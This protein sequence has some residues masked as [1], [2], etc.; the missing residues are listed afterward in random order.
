M[1]YDKKAIVEDQ[2]R[3]DVGQTIRKGYLESTGAF[4]NLYKKEINLKNEADVNQFIQMLEKSVSINQ[5]R[6]NG[7]ISKDTKLNNIKLTYTKSNLKKGFI[8]W[9]KCNRCDRRVKH[10]YMPENSE[11]L[12][13]R[14]C[15][16]LA[17]KKQNTKMDRIVTNLLKN[18]SL[19]DVYGRSNSL[20]QNLAALEAS[21]LIENIR[22]GIIS[23]I[24]KYNE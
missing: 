22:S 23:N 11:E 14:N 18:P 15:H 21:M 3:I 4:R 16:R 19:I 2:Q 8:F 20:K 10:L 7:S 13:C 5:T 24:K 17:Y 1:R 6:T 9:F 12:L